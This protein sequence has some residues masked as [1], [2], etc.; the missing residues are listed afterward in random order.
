M[1]QNLT[2]GGPDVGHLLFFGDVDIQRA[3]PVGTTS[4]RSSTKH[5]RKLDWIGFRSRIFAATMA[6]LFPKMGQRFTSF[7]QCSVIPQ[8]E[9]LKNTMHISHLTTLP[10][11]LFR[12]FRG[13]KREESTES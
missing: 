10:G 9:L 4:A 12:C 3:R 13:G 11:E 1:N 2:R 5:G 6:L 8:S 7:R